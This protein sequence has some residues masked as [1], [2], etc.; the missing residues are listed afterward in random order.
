MIPE[1]MGPYQL[2]RLLGMGGMGSVYLGRHRDGGY[3]AAIKVL[4]ASLAREE[5]FVVRFQREIE[6]LRQLKSPHIAQFY[7]DGEDDGTFY[8]AMEYVEGETLTDLLMRERRLPW[9][10]VVAMVL[11]MCAALKAAHDAGII[12][13]DLKP[14]NLLVSADRTVKLTDFGVAQVFAA[15][16][17]TATG[18][19]I[20]TAEYMSPEQAQGKRSTRRSDLYSLGAVMYVMLTGRPPFSGSAAIEVLKK[21]QYGQFDRPRNYVPELPSW[22]D[23]LVCQLLDKDPEKRPPDAYVVSKRLQE[24]LAKVELQQ[25]AGGGADLVGDGETRVARGEERVVGAT[26]MRDAV[27][28]E[29]MK[30][31][32]P[33]GLSG[34]LNNIWVLLGLLTLLIAGGVYMLRE[35]ELNSEQRFAR[36]VQLMEQPAGREWLQARSEFFD[37]LVDEDPERWQPQVSGYLEEI[38][39]YELESRIS[40]RRRSSDQQQ[41]TEPERWLRQV[42]RQ[43]DAGDLPGAYKLL[44]DLTP[45]LAADAESAPLQKLAA[46]WNE[47]LKTLLAESSDVVGYL[48][49]VLQTADLEQQRDPAAAKAIWTS[50]IGLYESHPEAAEFVAIARQRLQMQAENAAQKS[51]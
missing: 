13:R 49:R 17:L 12:H 29:L 4:P 36:G 33:E 35:R 3:L 21:H 45:L 28:A 39:L 11:Q 30:D 46:R 43:W 19:I 32:R 9:R 48:K 22:L 50:V 8:Y 41:A 26:L 16:R 15:S 23:E 14:S 7:D 20:G 27:R 5:G 24:I 18:G 6:A 1:R 51:E 44:N 40:T 42:R 47:Q 2:E 34:L 10:E 31:S 38:S 25:S 37:P